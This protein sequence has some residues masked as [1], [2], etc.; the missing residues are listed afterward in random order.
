M[1]SITKT[2][3]PQI[4]I[5]TSEQFDEEKEGLDDNRY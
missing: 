2:N 3:L 1:N 5:V 4:L